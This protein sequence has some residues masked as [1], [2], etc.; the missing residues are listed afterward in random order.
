MRG[1]LYNLEVINYM[2]L[3]QQSTAGVVVEKYAG[4]RESG[5]M[6]ECDSSTVV[7]RLRCAAC[8][9][10]L[11]DCRYGREHCSLRSLSLPP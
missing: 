10:R 8:C 9:L 11:W 6:S 7:L 5:S 1:L 2:Y 4:R 3:V